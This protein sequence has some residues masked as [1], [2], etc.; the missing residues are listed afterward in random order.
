VYPAAVCA[1]ALVGVVVLGFTM[2]PKMAEI[3]REMNLELPLPTLI[4]MKVFTVLTEHWYLLGIPI[5]FVFWGLR[6]WKTVKH[7][8]LAEKVMVRM[9]V[10]GV[11]F[12][13][14]ALVR[15][16]RAYA[17][18]K[19]SGVDIVSSFSIAGEVASHHEYRA[20]FQGIGGKHLGGSS[21]PEAFLLEAGRIPKDGL[22]LAGQVDLG[23]MVQDVSGVLTDYAEDLDEKIQVL[24]S[25]LPSLL[26][27]FLMLFLGFGVGGMI[28]AIY[29][30]YFNMMNAL[31]SQIG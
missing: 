30:P 12:R 8:R 6:N 7:S 16:I 29:Y 19:G 1:I 27:P 14:A 3:Y 15:S 4:L 5:F 23:D 24:V 26:E 22:D 21:L 2:V 18:V 10:F 20:Y 31:V 13:G 28:M 11:I 25:T 17:L 9:P